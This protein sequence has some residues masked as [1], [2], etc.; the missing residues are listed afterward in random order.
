MKKG[1]KWIKNNWNYVCVMLIPWLIVIAHSFFRNSWLSGNGSILTGDAADQYYELYMELWDKVHN[2]ESL[3]FSWNAGCG[4]DFLTNMIYYLVSPFSLF[5]LAVPRTFVENAVQ[6]I[7]VLK[8]GLIGLSMNYYLQH[9]ELIHFEK[10]RKWI[11]FVLGTCFM[12]CN[13]MIT[14]F[15]FF[16]WLDVIILFPLVL[17]G[18]EDILFRKKWKKYFVLL[19][20]SIICNFYTA[21]QMCI[22]CA[23]WFVVWI[24]SEDEK[25]NKIKMFLTSSVIAA[26]S[27]MIVI[28]PS[29][30][31]V[32]KRYA[33]ETAESVSLFARSFL[34]SANKVVS[35]LFI[36][37]YIR[38][39]DSFEPAL[40]FSIGGITAVL[41]LL[42]SKIEERKKIKI[43]IP[44]IILV[45]S[46]FVGGLNVVWHG[47]SVPNGSYNR[48]TYLLIF[49]LLMCVMLLAEHWKQIRLRTVMVAGI[50]GISLFCYAFFKTTDLQEYYV[51]LLTILL[52]VFYLIL[53]VLVRKK[54]ISVKAFVYV[55]FSVML[56]EMIG[57]AYYEFSGYSGYTFRESDINNG[58]MELSENI[59]CENGERVCSVGE[60][61]N[62]GM[63]MGVPSDGVFVSYGNGNMNRL[64]QNL[65]MSY[66]SVASYSLYGASPLLNY[67]FDIRYGMAPSEHAFS[68]VNIIEQRD[69]V[70]LFEMK[71]SSGLGYM[72]DKDV[73]LWN[74]DQL[75]FDA[76]NDFVNRSVQGKDIFKVLKPDIKCYN[77]LGLALDEPD[78]DRLKNNLYRTA[79]KAEFGNMN[80][81]SVIK[82]VIPED[83]D[84]Y[85][86]VNNG[87]GVYPSLY[88]NDM[89]VYDGANS[90]IQ[91]TIHV[92]KVK[93]GDIVNLVQQI[94]HSEVGENYHIAVHMAAFDE[95]A[96]EAAYEKLSDSMMEVTEFSSDYVRGTITAK[97]E[98]I[99][100]TSVPAMDGFTVYVD[101]K[102]QE[103]EKV[104][105]A[106][107][108]ISL[109]EGEH[110][111]E[112]RYCTPG[113]WIGLA[114]SVT[115]FL[116]F[117]LLCVWEKKNGRIF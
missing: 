7:M 48:F 44:L 58:A 61:Y 104:G 76:Q 63:V 79:V 91:Y 81:C 27:S 82:Y 56:V 50:T 33:Y 112:F 94:Y 70:S 73:L 65:G 1:I 13:Y 12:L 17:L 80:D 74:C 25:K 46:V 15:A 102:M 52:F 29:L 8:W 107:I 86:C 47:F 72:V 2:G 16:N 96:F 10:Y 37:D 53:F 71:D 78:A 62:M 109:P 19:L 117:G 92:G 38:N 35:K 45:L 11:S 59:E 54:S 113:F 43:F 114:G 97:E 89:L 111:I 68:N 18:I 30:L 4:Y 99:L 105:D 57:N 32:Q 93:K 90:V 9:T 116:L 100:M 101:G 31:G 103:Y 21:W 6:I 41:V 22:F 5:V 23:I 42:F 115:G 28:V 36:C 77:T 20:C 95:Q 40:Y 75:P 98:G 39:T 64:M 49:V 66:S 83:M 87:K 26:M 85:M 108:G 14:V 69:G 55:F 106:L 67:M 34:T 24:W 88:I 84:L 60:Q 51:Y 3:F 110:T